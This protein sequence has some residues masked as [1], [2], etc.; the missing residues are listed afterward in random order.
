MMLEIKETGRIRSRD[1][2]IDA[3]RA[4]KFW[5]IG[6][7][8]LGL[9]LA[10]GGAAVIYAR[11]VESRQNE[12]KYRAAIAAAEF[13]YSL[14]DGLLHRLIFQESHFRTDIISGK[15]VSG[16]GAVG[17][18]QIV[19]KWHPGV[20]P[21]DPFASIDYAASYLKQL[22]KQTGSWS[23]AIAAYNWGL[24]NL[25]RSGLENAPA[26]TREYVAS[27]TADVPGLA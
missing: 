14:P 17:I 26:E 25:K 8:L 18:A 4:K 16:A 3:M 11:T 10:G 9:L 24:G 21:L 19:P 7:V 15:T 5:I 12:E 13:K 22:R 20:D 1:I 27:I 23:E 2:L 6:G